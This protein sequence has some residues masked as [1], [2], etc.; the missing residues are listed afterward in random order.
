MTDKLKTIGESCRFSSFR[1]E[2]DRV[3]EGM[4]IFVSG[5]VGV[6]SYSLEEIE[7]KSH[8]GRVKISG[9]RLKMCLLENKTVEIR[10]KVADMVFSY[11]KG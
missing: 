8:G 9:S 7:L 6:G 10:G 11:G 2:A 1:I 3:A 4:R 5:I